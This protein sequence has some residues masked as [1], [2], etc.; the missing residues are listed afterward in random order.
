MLCIRGAKMLTLKN[1]CFLGDKPFLQTAVML[2]GGDMPQDSGLLQYIKE[3]PYLAAADGGAAAALGLGCCPNLLIGDFDSLPAADLNACKA[4]GAEVAALPQMKD[5]TDGEF[6]FSEL[7][8]RGFR[9]L[10][11]LGALGGRPD[12]Q[13]A[14]IFC[15]EKAA[16]DGLFCLLAHDN[17]LLL[18]LYAESE[19]QTLLL[20]GFAGQT[21]SLVSLSES[22]GNIWLD[23]F[24]YPL[25]DALYRRQTRGI[26]NIINVEQAKISLTMGSLLVI[27]NR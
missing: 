6:L 15:A 23:G 22:C 21:A 14:N 27:I 24:F 7:F 2:L 20:E 10:L 26:S 5:W 4:Q 16:R 8:G 17:A 18:P 3:A 19:P 12:Q 9:R 25:N 1:N 13:L 11:V